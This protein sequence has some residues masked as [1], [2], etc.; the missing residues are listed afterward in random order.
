MLMPAVMATCPIMFSHAV[1][2]AHLRPPSRKVRN[3][4]AGGRIRRRNF[5][6]RERVV[7]VITL[8]SGQP[9]N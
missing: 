1:V 3:R 9:M 6:H 2:H 8:T 4:V 7:S 5:C